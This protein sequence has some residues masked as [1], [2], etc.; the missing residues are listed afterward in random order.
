ML[1]N[2]IG[3]V[4]GCIPP[5][6]KFELWQAVRSHYEDEE[7]MTFEDEGIIIGFFYSPSFAACGYETGWWY[8]IYWLAVPSASYVRL[9]CVTEVSQQ[10][11]KAV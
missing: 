5:Q 4:L 7:L 8:F 1:Q 3:D 9:P 10:D 2:S 6:P 11:L